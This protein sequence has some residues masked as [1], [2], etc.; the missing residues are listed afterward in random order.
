M[1]GIREYSSFICKICAQLF[2]S[3]N[4]AISH[5]IRTHGQFHLPETSLLHYCKL[6]DKPISRIDTK[7]VKHFKQHIIGYA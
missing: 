5:V 1:K 3:E 2:G 6:C 7:F 4:K